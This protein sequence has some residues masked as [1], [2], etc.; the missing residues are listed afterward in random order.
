MTTTVNPTTAN[1]CQDSDACCSSDPCVIAKSELEPDCFKLRLG[2]NPS[3]PPAYDLALCNP[4]VVFTGSCCLNLVGD[5]ALTN[6]VLRI[7]MTFAQDCFL[8]RINLSASSGTLTNVSI[9]KPVG[10][11]DSAIAYTISDGYLNVI[12]PSGDIIPGTNINTGQNTATIMFDVFSIPIL[13]ISGL[14]SCCSLCNSI[15]WVMGTTV[16]NLT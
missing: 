3:S 15:K 9:V 5:N 10:G 14:C 16:T 12:I 13:R 11:L 7:P 2:F 6:I 1:Y 4:N 8:Y